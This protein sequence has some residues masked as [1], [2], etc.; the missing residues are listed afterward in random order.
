MAKVIAVIKIFPKDVNVNLG[1][2]KNKIKTSIPSYASALK[3]EE[4]PIAFGLV[5]LKLYV[6]LPEEQAGGMEEIETTLQGLKLV[7]QIE[8]QMV[9]RA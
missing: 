4:E 9:T 6:M 3:F 2:L 8:T 7:S 1:T 5:A